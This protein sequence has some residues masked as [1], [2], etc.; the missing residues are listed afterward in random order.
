MLF[1][2]VV[3]LL[4][5]LVD[6][7]WRWLL[8]L[9]AS[10]Y[11]YMVF[12]PAYILILFAIIAIDYTAAIWMEKLPG[13]KKIFLLLSIV[14]NLSLLAVFKYYNFFTGNVN[15]LLELLNVHI[16]P[17]PV[18]KIILPVGLSFHT[19]QAMSYTIEVYRGHQ[20]AEKH[21]GIYALYVMFYPQLVAGPIERPSQLL[22]QFYKKHD[23][24][25]DGIIRGLKMMLWGFFMK[26][27]VA[28]RLALYVDYV[29]AHA[30]WHGRLALIISV[31]FYSFQIYGDFA[32]Y[33]LIAIG[34]AKT[35]GFT[36]EDNFHQPYLS[37]SI[38]EFWR[39]WHI[40]LSGWFRDYVYIPLGGNR[41]GPARYLF[42]IL[43]VFLLSGLWHGANWTF[44]VWGLLHGF[45]IVLEFF[46]GKKIKGS[47]TAGIGYSFIIVSLCW[48][49]FRSASL[50]D[51]MGFIGRI[52]NPATPWVVA[53]EFNARILLVYSFFGIACVLAADFRKAFLN[54]DNLLLHHKKTGIRLVSCVAILVLIVLLGVFDGAQFIYFQF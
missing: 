31:F 33:S 51:A 36:L 16:S 45:F 41:N 38:T 8:L 34:A 47:R 35:I 30:E 18:W 28:D 25:Y 2:P 7:R 4:Y 24:D 20:K 6:Y 46:L 15:A 12:I 23:A 39:R 42:N 19:F 48:V 1:F 26:V 9:L 40:T 3:T 43:L 54:R 22:P 37:A 21:F 13:K 10:C 27:V 32:G 5:Y 50:H 17:L 53:G 11:F 29:Y 14:A 52:F 44:V 49:F